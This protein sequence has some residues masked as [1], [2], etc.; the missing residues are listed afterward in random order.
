MLTFNIGN[1]FKSDLIKSSGIY[2]IVN[3]LNK[4]FP[5]ILLPIL[6]RE[7]TLE[8]FGEYSIYRTTISFCI[9][10]V[11]LSLSEFIIRKFFEDLN[12]NYIST[13]LIQVF[14]NSFLLLLFSFFSSEF[15]F[16]SLGIDSILF[17]CA[18]LISLST[19]INNI[20]RGILRCVNNNS[21]FA[22]LVLGQ[23]IL[24]FLIII[25][26]YWFLQ[27]S[28]LYVVLVEV[29]VFLVFSCISIFLLCKKY[30]FSMNFS[31]PYISEGFKYSSPL[32]LNS[33]MIY[34]F[35]LLDRYIINFKL[36]PEDVALYV[37]I[38]QLSS[39]FQVLG[40]SFN[41]AWYPWVFKY[42]SNKP[43]SN[44]IIRYNFYVLASFTFIS[45]IFLYVSYNLVGF[46]LGNKYMEG[47][48]LL[49]GFV[50]A[51]LF[52]ITYWIF[53]PI[54]QFYKKNWI[55]TYPIIPILMVSLVL[56]L[57]FLSQYG[58]VFSSLV[59]SLSWFI[60]ACITIYYS[61]KFNNDFKII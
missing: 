19:N 37:G 12:K 57:S 16:S 10:L 46:I 24:Y 49:F 58:V 34:S 52:Q 8:Q 55:L 61:I 33:L 23:S 2:T 11:G 43:K 60:L 39:I 22:A 9:P 38:F 31:L 25:Y 13:I 3:F 56:N 36:G 48:I 18:V 6:S 42:L 27:I 32:F 28:L 4:V 14:L 45:L 41:S 7:F 54:I 50:S 26:A 20:H 53:S 40:N 21:L 59:Y 17:S 29:I 30:G 44:S 1:I 35:A 15:I 5:F 51:I 47:K